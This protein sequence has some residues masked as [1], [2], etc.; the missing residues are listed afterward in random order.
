MYKPVPQTQSTN[1]GE[2]SESELF[3][4]TTNYDGK[5]QNDGNS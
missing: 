1:D 5:S 4:S 3:S 2:D